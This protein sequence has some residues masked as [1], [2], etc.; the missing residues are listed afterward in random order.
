M[1]QPSKLITKQRV[2]RLEKLVES[3]SHRLAEFARILKSVVEQSTDAQNLAARTTLVLKV[4]NDKGLITYEEI[5]AIIQEH[6]KSLDGREVQPEDAGS[7]E[8]AGR[9]GESELLPDG[10]SGDSSGV[11]GNTNPESGVQEDSTNQN[12]P[13]SS[14]GGCGDGK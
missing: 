1:T 2:A 9:S 11:A 10:D 13:P 4:L 12:H 3:Q 6:S 7:D 14:V 5:D 8:D